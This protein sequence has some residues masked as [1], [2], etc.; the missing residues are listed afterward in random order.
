MPTNQA[1]LARITTR[2]DVFGGKPIVRDLRVSVELVLSLLAQGVTQEDILD[3]YPDLEP[4]DVRACIAYA[5]A[6]ISG[7]LYADPTKGAP[8][9]RQRGVTMP[10]TNRALQVT[11]EIIRKDLPGHLGEGFRISHIESTSIRRSKRDVN[12]MTVYLEPG[13][14]PLDDDA[15][16]GFDIG[17][18][19]RLMGQRIFDK[20]A[21]AYIDREDAVT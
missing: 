4:D 1:L 8:D 19:E 15:F 10:R 6:V 21:V 17:L 12:Y 20:P 5:H 9:H 7:G 3:D 14:P 11:E 13:H 2:P 16:I 18:R